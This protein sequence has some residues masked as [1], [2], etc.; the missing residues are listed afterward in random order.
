[1]SLFSYDD[2]QICSNEKPRQLNDVPIRFHDRGTGRFLFR[3]HTGQFLLPPTQQNQLQ[4]SNSRRLI[5][6]IFHPFDPFI[7]TI[8]RYNTH[9]N[10]HLHIRH[11]N[12]L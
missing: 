4:A 6:F 11:N 9:Y 3:L 12:S 10:V 2:K 8:Q 1:M 5:A 7:I